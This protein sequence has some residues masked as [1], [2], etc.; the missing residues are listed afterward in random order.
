MSMF[1]VR[2]EFPHLPR[3]PLPSEDPTK[4]DLLGL[5]DVQALEEA[6]EDLP[7]E[8]NGIASRKRRTDTGPGSPTP[9]SSE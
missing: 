8:L 2:W 1:I 5:D 6:L 4:T 3:L 9:P 7:D